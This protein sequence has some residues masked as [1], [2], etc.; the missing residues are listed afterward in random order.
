MNGSNGTVAGKRIRWH[1]ANS[2]GLPVCGR[3]LSRPRATVANQAS[4][5]VTFDLSEVKCK[6]CLR[7]IGALPPVQQKLKSIHPWQA[8]DF[9]A[10]Y[11]EPEE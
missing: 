8:I 1:L 3:Q 6:H 11:E 10:E 4:M 7:A 2:Q 5:Q 9:G